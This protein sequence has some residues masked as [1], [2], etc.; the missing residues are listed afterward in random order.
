ML[1]GVLAHNMAHTRCWRQGV[2]C[3]LLTLP[4]ANCR[5]WE[6]SPHDLVATGFPIQPQS[7]RLQQ[8]RFA[9][10]RFAKRGRRSPAEQRA[11]SARC[12]STGTRG[13]HG[14]P[15][16]KT[17]PRQA[18][19]PVCPDHRPRPAGG[20]G[21]RR[22]SA[23]TPA[24]GWLVAVSQANSWRSRFNGPA[25]PACPNSFGTGNPMGLFRKI[26]VLCTTKYF[27]APAVL[28]SGHTSPSSTSPV[29]VADTGQRPGLGLVGR[30]V[31]K[32]RHRLPRVRSAQTPPRR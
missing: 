8:L 14:R 19:R 32:W 13:S 21:F 24:S 12:L 29:L 7:R 25:W 22:A 5:R 15:S 27:T 20:R 23:L 31:A 10:H 4:V 28:L 2:S 3:R 16:T 9:A 6:S 30:F 1:S 11:A 26:P 17:T 18:D